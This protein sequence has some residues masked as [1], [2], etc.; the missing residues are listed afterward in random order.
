MRLEIYF[1]HLSHTVSN[2]SSS[3]TTETPDEKHLEHIPII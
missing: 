3:N 1:L 2:D